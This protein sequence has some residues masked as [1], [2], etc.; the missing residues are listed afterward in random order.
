MKIPEL[1][2]IGRQCAQYRRE[3]L[4]RT[5]GDVAQDVR[6]SISMV[7]LFEHGRTDSGRIL[8]WYVERGFQ[9]QGVRYFFNGGVKHGID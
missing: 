1:E 2:I 8:L 3:V 4:R 5:Q 7:S 9:P 6:V